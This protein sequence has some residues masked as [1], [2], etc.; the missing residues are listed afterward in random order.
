MGSDQIDLILSILIV[1]LLL[2]GG[3]GY[4]RYGY[5]GGIEMGIGGVLLVVLIVYWLPGHG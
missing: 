4:R 2:G 5:G 3:F 1:V